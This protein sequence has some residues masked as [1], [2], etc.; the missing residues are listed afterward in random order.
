MANVK[1]VG[2]ITTYLVCISGMG[3]Y[4]NYFYFGIN[5]VLEA[6]ISSGPLLIIQGLCIMEYKHDIKIQVFFIPSLILTLVSF[7]LNLSFGI[8]LINKAF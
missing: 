8:F 1:F 2:M 4:F 5:A 3:N 7:L 6:L